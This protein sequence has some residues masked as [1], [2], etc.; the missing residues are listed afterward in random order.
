MDDFVITINKRPQDDS[1]NDESTEPSNQEIMNEVQSIK[2]RLIRIESLLELLVTSNRLEEE[3]P[4]ADAVNVIDLD[5]EK[6][7]DNI[8]MVEDNE[9]CF[10]EELIEDD[11]DIEKVDQSELDLRADDMKHQIINEGL[12]FPLQSTQEI[13]EMERS[14]ISVEGF[15]QEV[16]SYLNSLKNSVKVQNFS[17]CLSLIATDK[18]LYN[19]NWLGHKLYGKKSMKTMVLFSNLLFGE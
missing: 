7:Q 5:Y 6:I 17:Y 8:E 11:L 1:D 4:E 19:I 9:S 18:A 13:E 14:M 3:F 2:H 10:E 12:S 16:K 15:Q